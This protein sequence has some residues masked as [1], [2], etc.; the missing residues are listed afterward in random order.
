MLNWRMKSTSHSLWFVLGLVLVGL[1]WL[2]AFRDIV[3][4]AVQGA[5]EKK[6]N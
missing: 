4:P 1:G 6:E 2:A 5:G 3:V